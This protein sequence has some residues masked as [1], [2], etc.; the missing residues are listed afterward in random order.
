MREYLTVSDVA[1]TVSMMH[2][3]FDGTL[4][5]VEGPTDHRLYGKFTDRSEV[6]T[7]I[8]YSKDNVK[9][10]VKEVTGR[11]GLKDVF[12]IVDADLDLLFGNR[13]QPPLFRTDTRDAESMI[14][15]SDSFREVLWEYADQEK[16]AAFESRYGDVVE[17]IE[18]AA[19]PI[20]LLMYISVKEDLRLSFKDLI[21]TDFIDTRSLK[22]DLHALCRAVVRNSVNP[23][24]DVRDLQDLLNDYMG[25]KHY[26]DEVC[27]G[28]DMVSI[29]GIGLRMVFGSDNAQH[30]KDSAIG[31]ALRLS[32]DM[33]QF[34]VTDLYRDTSQWAG[35][36]GLKLWK[37]R[38]LD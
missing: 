25:E 26:V 10:V 21:F 34:A 2:T 6:R 24:I 31:S 13:V 12:G 23:Q 33:D 5:V 8:A 20:G 3:A 15:S 9:G 28:H 18:D 29:L 16:L 22:C 27:R 36:N 17:R 35:R 32:Y 37:V 14:T 11:R 7:V 4:M 30:L 1:N 19:Y 38:S